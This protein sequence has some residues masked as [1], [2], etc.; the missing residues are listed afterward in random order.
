MLKIRVESLHPLPVPTMIAPAE[1]PHTEKRGKHADAEKAPAAEP[2]A[3]AKAEAKG[4]GEPKAEGKGK[5]EK[6][7][8]VEKK[9]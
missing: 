6:K 3:E 7:A 8:K 2:K 9:D 4:K 1:K 5:G